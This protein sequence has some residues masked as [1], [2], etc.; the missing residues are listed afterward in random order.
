M[1][2]LPQRK[3]ARH[4]NQLSSPGSRTHAHTEML[5]LTPFPISLLS[6]YYSVTHFSADLLRLAQGRNVSTLHDTHTCNALFDPFYLYKYTITKQKSHEPSPITHIT[7]STPAPLARALTISQNHLSSASSST[8]STLGWPTPHTRM[9]A[10]RALMRYFRRW[11]RAASCC[12]LSSSQCAGD[13]LI[14]AS[15]SGA[16]QSVL[17]TL[18]AAES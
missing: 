7:H 1:I 2:P 11:M 17:I 12:A 13:A 15:T 3:E 16:A 18:L 8:A 9:M 14:T 4:F 10:L 6:T 5:P